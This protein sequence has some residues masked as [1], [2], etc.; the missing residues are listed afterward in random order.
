V[1][2]QAITTAK[3][4]LMHTITRGV[5]AGAAVVGAAIGLAGPAS[6]EL[7]D[8]TYQITYIGD[9]SPS[10]NMVVNSCGDGCKHIQI[11]GPY[12]PV[13]Y[14][15][16]GNIWTALSYGRTLTINDD[17]LGGSAGSNPFSLTKAG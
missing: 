1:L 17:T 3:E 8:G 16:Q 12:E 2:D 10:Q 15:L 5:I 7:T 11:V 13:D 6:A 9:P 14:H 4:K